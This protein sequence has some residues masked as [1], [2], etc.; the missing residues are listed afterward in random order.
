MYSQTCLSSLFVKSWIFLCKPKM[1]GIL[2][3]HVWKSKL[4]PES[5]LCPKEH[6]QNY[7]PV[8][9]LCQ[10]DKRDVYE[11]G[12]LELLPVLRLGG[13]T[14]DLRG[15]LRWLGRYAPPRYLTGRG[16]GRSDRKCHGIHTPG[17]SSTCRNHTSNLIGR[18]PAANLTRTDLVTKRSI[19][20]TNLEENKKS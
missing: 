7:A 16:R 10:I 20:T 13:E 12:K 5:F 11:E 14:Q 18:P 3:A 6:G 4:T 9:L 1:Y 8:P 19:S 2:V 17:R 15:E